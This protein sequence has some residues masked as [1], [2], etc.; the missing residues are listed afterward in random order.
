MIYLFICKL[1]QV[2][3]D[4]SREKLSRVIDLKIRCGSC[5]IPE[6]KEFQIDSNYTILIPDYMY[7]GGDG[8]YMFKGLAHTDLSKFI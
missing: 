3:Y 2:T 7:N 8:Y 6:Y 5:D 4:I 1:L